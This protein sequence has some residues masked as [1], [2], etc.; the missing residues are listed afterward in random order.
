MGPLLEAI[1]HSYAGSFVADVDGPKVIDGSYGAS[2]P[3]RL[4]LKDKALTHQL[5]KSLDVPLAFGA[6]ASEV[7]ERSQAR[8]GKNSDTLDAVRTI[9]EEIGERLQD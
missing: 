4:A 9:E 5:G 1:Q 8:F 3:V 7:L 2:F 6:L